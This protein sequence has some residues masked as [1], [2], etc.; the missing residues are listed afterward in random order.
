[1]RNIETAT[2]HK[3]KINKASGNQIILEGE[4]PMIK[5]NMEFM[6]IVHIISDT[7]SIQTSS[8]E[9]VLSV[10]N[11]KDVTVYISGYSDYLPNYPTFKGRNF[12]ND[13]KN[14]ISKA[15]EVGYNSEMILAGRR[16]NDGMGSYIADQVLKLM[17]KKRIHIVESNVLIMGL[18][19]K[20]NCPDIR[21]TK[22]VDVIRSLNS[23]ETNV[24]IFDPWA[25][26][27]EVMKEYNIKSNQKI[28]HTKF[29]AIILTVAHKEFLELDFST[30][31]NSDTVIYDVKGVLGISV[32]GSL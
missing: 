11:A 2:K 30:I 10:N 29:D 27:L 7:G 23:Y 14:T 1:M 12:R 8:E 24:T 19:F 6:Q 3:T 20:E 22:V 17:T 21:N 18:T 28:P 13:T 26:S 9:G 32:S 31:T 15:L 25:D 4:T 16:L 5:N